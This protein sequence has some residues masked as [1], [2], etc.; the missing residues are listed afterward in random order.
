MAGHLCRT[1]SLLHLKEY[2]CDVVLRF[3]TGCCVL[4]RSQGCPSALKE[5]RRYNQVKESRGSCQ[6]AGTDVHAL[7]RVGSKEP[8]RLEGKRSCKERKARVTA[9]TWATCTMVSTR[10]SK[11][12]TA[13]T[14]S[15]AV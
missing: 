5:A 8:R 10:E 14:R 13:S 15:R 6:P 9:G 4:R 7:P 1:R 11:G 12:T 3:N 2:L